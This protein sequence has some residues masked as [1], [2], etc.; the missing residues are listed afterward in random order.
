MSIICLS[1]VE[2]VTAFT[3]MSTS[4]A[5]LQPLSASDFHALLKTIQ[6]TFHSSRLTVQHMESLS[7]HLYHVRLLHL[8][9]GSRVILKVNPPV[10]A[11][12]LK[13]ER[14]GL[15]TEALALALLD[16]SS[17]PVSAVLKYER[18]GA[19]LGSP[20]LI[21]THL[22]GIPLSQA[23]PTLN[24]ADRVGIERQMS[25]LKMIIA[26]HTS[27][28][29]GP[30]PLVS[31]G[32]GYK[33]WRE[34]YKAMLESVLKDAE[35]KFVNI[36]YAQI[37]EQVARTEI[38][39]DEVQEARLVVLGLGNAENV[40]IDQSTREITGLADFKRTLWGDALMGSSEGANGTRGL[41]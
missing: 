37:R 14:Q 34:A 4:Q 20:F 2:V 3:A 35:D 5:T 32:L 25:A 39:L 21:T 10:S 9:N 29:F 8:S 41:L 27:P 31:S 13:H 38:A 19:V 16:Q 17:L 15:E 1:P 40:L 28:T 26:Q 6:T 36:P 7:N 30:M 22:Q 24:R 23:L 33:S 12:L 11:A 18:S